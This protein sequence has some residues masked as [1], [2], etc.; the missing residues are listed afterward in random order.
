MKF[1]N[2]ELNVSTL[3][4]SPTFVVKEEIRKIICDKYGFEGNSDID[5][6]INDIYQAIC[7]VEL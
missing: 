7:K 1:V 3:L 4:M 6:M 5:S 2:P